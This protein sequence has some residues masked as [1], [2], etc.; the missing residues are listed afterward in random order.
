MG[1]YPK[2]QWNPNP[3][4]FLLPMNEVKS[5]ALPLCATAQQAHRKSANH[6][7]TETCKPQAETF[8]LYS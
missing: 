1:T 4:L 8:L 7:Q 5:F 6:M 3:L 2:G